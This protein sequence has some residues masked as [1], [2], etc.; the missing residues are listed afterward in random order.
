[1]SQSRYD[2]DENSET[3]PYFVLTG[4]LVPLVPA[5]ISFVM[6]SKYSKSI[7][8]TKDES[9]KSIK[10]WF[11]PYN[12]KSIE[13]YNSNEKKKSL[14]STH[15]IILLIGWV[16]VFGLLYLIS[17]ID[18]QVSES[19]FDPWKI[20]Q[21]DELASEKLIKAAYRKLSLKFHPDKVDTK[22][23]SPKEIDEVDSAYVL[24]NKAYKALTDEV[25][26]ENF[27]KYGNPDG[28]NEIKHGIALPKFL[29]EGSFSPIVILIYVLLI[30]VALPLFV[31]SWWNGVKSKTKQGLHV[32][33]A[34]YFMKVMINSNPAKLILLEDIFGFLS[35]SVEYK[36]IDQ[37]LTPE[38]IKNFLL[39]YV[40]REEDQNDAGL[41][42]KIVSI[43]PNLIKSFIEIA[44]AFR[45]TEYCMKLVDAHRCLIQALNIE[46]DAKHNQ[47]KQ[48]L[49]LPG[50]D[51]KKVDFKQHILTM[52]KLIKNPTVEPS[53]FFGVEESISKNIIDYA[54]NLP[55][56]EPIECK[57]MVSGED[58][59]PI[60]S[61]THLDLKFL[62]KSPKHKG[63]VEVKNLS[64]EIQ[65]SIVNEPT[66]LEYLRD[67]IKWTA[68]QPLIELNYETPFFPDQNYVKEN[69][70]W[71]AF[72]VDQRDNKII[73]LPYYLNRG[74]ISN[75]LLDQTKFEKSDCLINH[76]KL[77]IQSPTPQQPGELKYRLVLRNMMYFGSDLDIPVTMKVENRPIE[78]S[79]KDVYEIEDPDE[80][81]V[82]G[83][84]AQLRGE[85]V[86]RVSEMFESDD[87]EEEGEDDEEESDWTD[88]DTDTDIEQDPK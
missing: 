78:V 43:T 61:T 70:G 52:G 66:E 35:N 7:T 39:S 38:L 44:T 1:M 23:M 86:K 42:L 6:N 55:L 46:A 51:P 24:I 13:K 10:N 74:S 56:I 63:S 27:L 37:S 80:D 4:F 32:N 69:F 36:E 45:N 34:D 65:E 72:L 20:L 62:L 48:I 5:T 33:T 64:D 15:S 9:F 82:A 3:W 40:N 79:K 18:V 16:T 41:R 57:F 75:L 67:P 47:F 26:K 17:K 73:E 49:Q 22:S 12:S 30:A 50:V 85:K 87:D 54:S 25:T 81:S 83:A 76:F 60:L 8:S 68:N 71:I 58:H 21:I 14:V 77:P 53:K 28:P 59:V 11:K 19:N 31:S 88:I 84:M 29:I 2:Y